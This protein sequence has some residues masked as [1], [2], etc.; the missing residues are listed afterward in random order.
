MLFRNMPKITFFL[1]GSKA[2]MSTIYCRVS[3]FGESSEFSLK[4]KVDPVFWDQ[5]AQIYKAE[6]PQNR[7]YISMLMDST[8]FKLKQKA[9]LE[10]FTSPSALIFALTAKKKVIERV[11]LSDIVNDYINNQKAI[12]NFAT[13]KHHLVKLA[14][15][16]EYQKFRKVVFA[17]A[18]ESP[19]VIVFDLPEAEMFK[20]WFQLRINSKNKTTASRNVEL[21]KSALQFAAKTGIL[22]Y[23]ELSLYEPI[24]DQVNK[25]IFLSKDEIL[26]LVSSSFESKMLQQTK[27]LYLFQIGTGLSYCDLWSAWT[28]KE[29]ENGKVLLGER[30]KN[31]QA[32]FVPLEQFTLDLLDKYSSVMP[33]YANALYNR[34]LKRVA[35]K[36]GIKKRLTTHSGRKTFATMMDESGWS[37]ESIA[38]MLGH[39]SVKTTETYYIGKSFARVE[40]EMKGRK[41]S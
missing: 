3:M 35:Q 4:Q 34:N 22:T 1:R 37:M 7:E 25:P 23:F 36:L 9:L 39:S 19:S 29:T 28:V 17:M 40:L 32:F 31:Q 14:N 24:R 21:Y 13:I 12:L 18:S 41:A 8:K 33:H 27:D 10:T 26:L 15:L 38:K 2:T 16:L 30:S 5:A 11:L 6:N 20:E